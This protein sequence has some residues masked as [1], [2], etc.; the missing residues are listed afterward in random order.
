MAAT[1]EMLMEPTLAMGH[2]DL[3]GLRLDLLRRSAEIYLALAYPSSV[4]P[5][6]VAH[7]MI[8]AGGDNTE[9]LLNGPPFER[10]GKAPGRATPIYALRL[11]NY[12]Y[13]HM[14]LQI[15]PWPNDAGFMLSVNSHD[16][17]T[18]LDLE[19]ADA[20][21]FQELQV[22]NQRLK[23]AIEL[24]WEKAGLPTFLHYL[25]DYIKSRSDCSPPAAPNENSESI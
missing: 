10:A 6:A 15:Q 12:R 17:V 11:G 7:R 22:E 20:Q 21:A 5:S 16:Q 1:K 14:K 23:E 25:R 4:I 8:W 2:D 3:H 24:A 13:P 9:E 19:A 18:S